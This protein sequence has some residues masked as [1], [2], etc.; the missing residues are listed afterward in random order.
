MTHELKNL[1]SK[2]ITQVNDLYNRMMYY[3]DNSNYKYDYHKY[4]KDY[5]KIRSDFSMQEIKILILSHIHDYVSQDAKNKRFFEFVGIDKDLICIFL[6][7]EYCLHNYKDFSSIKFIA[8]DEIF[9][10]YRGY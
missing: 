3:I 4:F 8:L 6:I 10:K 7:F 1:T 5:K 9:K 2:E